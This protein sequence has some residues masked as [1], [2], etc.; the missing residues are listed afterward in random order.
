M[1]F[2]TVG[3]LIK[4]LSKLDKSLC[5]YVTCEYVGDGVVPLSVGNVAVREEPLEAAAEMPTPW[6]EIGVFGDD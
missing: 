3:D 4:A 6:V 2:S 1:S 5:V